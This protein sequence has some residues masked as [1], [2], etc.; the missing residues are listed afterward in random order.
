ML[1]S[2]GRWCLCGSLAL[3]P[4]LLELRI[5]IRTQP[6]PRV[7]PH[8]PLGLPHSTPCTARRGLLSA[9]GARPPFPS[10]FPRAPPPRA[11]PA[12]FTS[13]ST[14]SA[15][16]VAG[17]A[18]NVACCCPRRVHRW[19]PAPQ[20]CSEW[21]RQ[22]QASHS[23]KQG[24]LQAAPPSPPRRGSGRGFEGDEST[25]AACPVAS[26]WARM[27]F[28]VSLIAESPSS[29]SSAVPE[30][31]WAA[32]RRMMPSSA[33]DT[34]LLLDSLVS[35]FAQVRPRALTFMVT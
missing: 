28:V 10:P 33:V 27:G 23:L 30:P 20:R 4:G 31:R 18:P 14:Y 11:P 21:V 13:C 15:R 7:H 29:S 5:C 8:K 34:D 9:S 17:A 19:A 25:P 6:I 35:A 24:R 22:V 3:H 2:R 16:A 12:S 32:S 1:V 26:G